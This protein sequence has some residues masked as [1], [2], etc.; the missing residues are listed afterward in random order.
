[1]QQLLQLKPPS[2]VDITK[3]LEENIMKPVSLMDLAYLSGRSLS[4]FKRDY[5]TIYQLP[6][7]QWL[8]NRWTAKA[9]ELL[10]RK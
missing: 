2:S 7:S 10:V 1:V 3:V 4:S 8:R 5:Y 9:K 6:T